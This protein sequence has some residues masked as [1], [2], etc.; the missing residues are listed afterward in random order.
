MNEEKSLGSL[1]QG[2]SYNLQLLGFIAAVLVHCL[3]VI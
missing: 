1:M 2:R 3:Y